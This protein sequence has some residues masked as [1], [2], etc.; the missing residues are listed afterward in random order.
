MRSRFAAACMRRARPCAALL[1]AGLLLGGCLS[2]RFIFNQLDWF[3]SW[4]LSSYFSL[5]DDQ[6]RELR[7]A[8][9][10]TLERVRSEQLPRVAMVLRAVEQEVSAGSVT[11][12]SM[13]AHYQALLASWDDF[14]R[15]AVPEAADFLSGLRAEQIEVLIDNLEDE[16][17]ELWDEFAGET[18]EQRLRRREKAIIKNLQRFSGRLNKAQKALVRYHVSLMHDNA[19]EWMQGRREWQRRFR[20]LL[21]ERPPP[22]ELR[23]RLLAM[24]LDPNAV[25]SP[26]YRRRVAENRRIVLELMSSLLLSLE[27]RQRQR[28]SRRLIGLAEDFEAL[29]AKS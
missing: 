26:D 8:V 18:P 2:T 6:E 20:A 15:M 16:N 22:A 12:E 4:R 11:P 23:Q 28:F 5:D 10:R 13:G 24:A 29:A 27:D 14:L 25:D 7:A 19:A 1:C 17:E 3:I 9:S 21:L